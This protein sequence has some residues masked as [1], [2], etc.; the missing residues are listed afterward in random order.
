MSNAATTPVQIEELSAD[1]YWVLIGEKVPAGC[2]AFYTETVFSGPGPIERL[3]DAAH[4]VRMHLG[5]GHWVD[6]VA[7]Y[8]QRAGIDG[9]VVLARTSY[10]AS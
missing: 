9:T 6:V 10:S 7:T 5:W 3:R 2:R 1:E 8:G 4:A